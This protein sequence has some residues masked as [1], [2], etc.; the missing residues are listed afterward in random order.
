MDLSDIEGSDAFV[1]SWLILAFG[2]QRVSSLYSVNDFPPT[3]TQSAVH[4]YHRG[5]V[6]SEL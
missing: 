6:S 4:T 3:V 2:V 5:A 1:F